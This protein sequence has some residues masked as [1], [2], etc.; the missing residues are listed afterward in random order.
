M[1]FGINLECPDGERRLCFPVLAHYIADYE[2]Q[3]MLASIISG[4]CP[5]CTIP[6]YKRSAKHNVPPG[7][8]PQ[9][10]PPATYSAG[11]QVYPPR[12]GD[13]AKRLRAQYGRDGNQTTD[14]DDLKAFGYHETIPF[15][16]HHLYSNIH[17]ALAPDILHQVLKCSYDYVHDWMLEVVKAQTGISLTKVEGEIDARFSQIPPY[18]GLRAFTNG[19]SKTSRWTGNEIRKMMRV[20]GGVIKGLV[21]DSCS[22]FLK[23]YLDILRMSEYMSHTESTLALLSTAINDFWKQL[24]DPRGPFA[25]IMIK[26]TDQQRI[27]PGWFAPKFH[28]LQHYTDQ[29]RSKG[30]LSFCSTNRTETWHKTIKDA[31]RR[32]NKGPQSLEFCVRDE[33]R[34]YAWAVWEADLLQALQ[35]QDGNEIMLDDV[36]T[37][38]GERR[39]TWTLTVG[40]EWKGFRGVAWVAD[41]LGEGYEALAT[42]TSRCLRWIQGGRNTTVTRSRRDG[43]W[44]RIWGRLDLS[45]HRQLTV[46]YPT[47]HDPRQYI[48][49]TIHSTKD[50]FYAQDKEWRQPRRDTALFRYNAAE[51]D[52]S[53]MA[54]RRVGRVLLLFKV[55]EP[56]GNL[57]AEISLAYVQWFQTLNC[58]KHSGMF[59]LKK[60]DSF[61]VVDIDTVERGAH[62]IP[63]FTGLDTKMADPDSPPA[64]DVYNEFWFNNQVDNHAYNTI[65]D[66][67]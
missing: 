23:N 58:D 49:E 66:L 5:K 16:E 20:Y 47:V 67:T 4:A 43:D 50:W 21:P 2:E 8:L 25:T 17:E 32:S 11:M 18:P 59:R 31:Y 7:L 40:K 41:E 60:M 52:Q 44:Q 34:R 3:R 24:W 64:L 12:K 53:T 19:I 28:Y 14:N 27:P 54:N 36:N 33:A 9:P 15:T 65:Y 62:L 48:T 30:V 22:S 55:K 26:N 46:T 38:T 61:D 45:V 10:Q 6:R 56:W 42:E 1:E 35:E 57:N 13:D 29:I 51:N 37:N 39:Q 63:C